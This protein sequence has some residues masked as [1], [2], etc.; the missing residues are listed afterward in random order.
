MSI[1]TSE[2]LRKAAD[3]LERDGWCQ[4]T[5]TDPYGRRCAF[6]AL[7]VARAYSDIRDDGSL[8]V[9]RLLHERTGGVIDWNDAPG[10]T[11]QEVLALFRNTADELEVDSSDAEL[12]APSASIDLLAEQVAESAER[13]A[14]EQRELV[15]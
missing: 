11:K 13:I 4:G 8:K 3:V 9:Y 6:G 10:R 1:T 14:N 12:S 7:Q 5:H 15:S 2:F